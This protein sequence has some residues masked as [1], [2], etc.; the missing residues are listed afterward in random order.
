MRTYE[1]PLSERIRTFLRLESLFDQVRHYARGESIWDSRAA[2][3]GLLEILAILG[4]GDIRSEVMKEMERQT[5]VLARLK[6]RSNVDTVRLG[7][8]LNTLELLTKKLGGNGSQ[9]GRELREHEFLSSIRQRSS[10]PGG[11]CGFDL[12]ALQHWLNQPAMLRQKTLNKWL[13]QIDPLWRSVTLLLMLTRESAKPTNELAESGLFQRGL[14]SAN[15]CHLI[16]VAVNEKL[17][18]FPEISG[19]KHRFTVRFLER[20]TMDERAKQSERDI[21]FQLICCQL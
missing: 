7:N 21:P 16:R 8:V 19:G 1:Q 13:E 2:I 3:D 15:S 17:N 14:D 4:R 10:I 6:S 11:T 5:S 18:V 20:T 12:P 9:I